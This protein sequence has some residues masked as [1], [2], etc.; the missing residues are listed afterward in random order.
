[1]AQTY[2][3]IRD[4]ITKLQNDAKALRTS[5]LAD[6][7]RR[8]KEAIRTYELTPRDLFGTRSANAGTAKR[9]PRSTSAAK[10]SDGKGGVWVGRGPRPQWLRDALASGSTL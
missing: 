6:V 2:A 9:K 5:E 3:Q 7:I 10:Y 8:I 4:Q 1:M